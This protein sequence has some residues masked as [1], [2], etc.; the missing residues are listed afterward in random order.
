MASR[1]TTFN[2]TDVREARLLLESLGY[3]VESHASLLEFGCLLSA[4]HSKKQRG[5][6]LD[7]TEVSI[8]ARY[9]KRALDSG[10]VGGW[11]DIHTRKDDDFYRLRRY[12][13]SALAGIITRFH[14]E[15]RPG[16]RNNAL[17]AAAYAVGRLVGGNMIDDSE[18][19]AALVEA[20]SLVFSDDEEGEV[21]RTIQSGMEAGA[22]NPA[23][24]PP[25]KKGSYTG[26][27]PDWAKPTSSK[28]PSW[29]ER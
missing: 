17:N 6:L 20:S 14:K 26:K 2:P 8:L 12:A 24:P 13:E 15:A 10:L 29:T 5:L 22:S 1:R 9:G 3:S 27:R 7:S 19:V 18:A 28:K 21:R 11:V 16:N 23:V 4:W 25:P